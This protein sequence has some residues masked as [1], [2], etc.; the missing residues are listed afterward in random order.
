RRRDLFC[1]AAA[2]ER[3]MISEAER[4]SPRPSGPSAWCR[5]QV[6]TRR[7]APAQRAAPHRGT[8]EGKGLGGA[9]EGKQGDALAPAHVLRSVVSSSAVVTPPPKPCAL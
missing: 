1:P 3:A 8:G 7:P 6:S 9:R 4:P 5:P 2:N